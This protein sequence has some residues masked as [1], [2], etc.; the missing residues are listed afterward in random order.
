PLR[1]SSTG[2]PPG[3]KIASFATF[4][5]AV[6]KHRDQEKPKN[7]IARYSTA[8][9]AASNRGG[10]S[11]IDRQYGFQSIRRSFDLHS[12]A[13]QEVSRGLARQ[14]GSARRQHG[15]YPGTLI[16]LRKP[17]ETP[18]LGKPLKTKHN[19]RKYSLPRSS[20]SIVFA[21]NGPNCA[22]NRREHRG[23]A[24]S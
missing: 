13:E 17:W 6:K 19:S 24:L 20:L 4:G 3:W 16:R 2:A 11:Q 1:S 10:L 22:I 18:E 8:S 14:S 21:S 5:Q 23:L 9:T 7:R 15:N 12:K